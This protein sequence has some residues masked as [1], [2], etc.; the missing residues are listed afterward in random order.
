MKPNNPKQTLG[1]V[2][3]DIACQ[4]L[5]NKGFTILQRNYRIRYGEIDIVCQKDGELIAVEVKTRSSSQ[6][7]IPEDAVTEKKI[8]EVT[9]TFTAYLLESKHSEVPARIDVIAIEIHPE[10]QPTIRHL[11]NVTG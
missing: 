4:F 6:F 3:E 9:K 2:G 5:Q 10:S 1:K 7:G 11:E 8:L